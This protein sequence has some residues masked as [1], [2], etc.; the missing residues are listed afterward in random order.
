[1]SKENKPPNLLKAAW[2]SSKI[3][4]SGFLNDARLKSIMA[5][6]RFVNTNCS[7][8]L[9]SHHHWDHM[10]GLFEFAKILNSSTDKFIYCSPLTKEFICNLSCK[11]DHEKVIGLEINKPFN[12]YE[13][14]ESY[15]TVTPL[16]AAHC[17]GSVMFL[18]EFNGK[19]ILYT[20]D[21]RMDLDYFKRSQRNLINS[22]ETFKGIDDLYLDSTFAL[23][24][25][26]DDFP[27]REDSEKLIIDLMESWFYRTP[28]DNDSRQT[29]KV[30]ILDIPACIGS[31]TLF[32]S[33]A[34]KFKEKIVVHDDKFNH[35][36]KRVE[37]LNSC[38]ESVTDVVNDQTWAIHACK[39]GAK[40]GDCFKFL[41]KQENLKI[42]VIKPCALRFVLQEGDLKSV[43]QFKH[44][45]PYVIEDGGQH[46]FAK[47][48]YSSHSSLK[49][50]IE[51]VNFIHPKRIFYNTSYKGFHD[52]INELFLENSKNENTADEEKEKLVQVHPVVLSSAEIVNNQ[53]KREQVSKKLK[54]FLP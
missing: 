6:D 5:I 13:L 43:F 50:L 39:L 10:D 41:K 20:G 34:K 28:S 25:A 49:E 22:D 42:S 45:V 8:F 40:K 37:T 44:D 1:M 21:F 27:P 54:L 32:I 18:I 31:E 9:L 16:P 15:V 26:F 12:V 52:K 47:V 46:S 51:V 48:L 33:I 3:T 19:K 2:S 24:S 38:M 29:R 36:Y 30:V 4:F 23:P 14:Q 35:F 7:V 11:I 17:P 53:S